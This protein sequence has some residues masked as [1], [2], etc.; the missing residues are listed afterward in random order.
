ML[1]F[2]DKA[3]RLRWK[4]TLI[5]AASVVLAIVVLGIGLGYGLKKHNNSSSSSSSGTGTGSTPINNSTDLCATINTTST[6]TNPVKLAST[7]VFLGNV[8]SNNTNDV[9][10]TGWQGNIGSDWIITFADTVPCKGAD[11]YKCAGLEASNSAALATSNP[12][13]Y[14][15]IK[16][17]TTDHAEQFIPRF[18]NESVSGI[19]LWPSAVLEIGTNMGIVY[20]TRLNRSDAS[21]LFVEGTGCA[22]VDTS[23]ARPIAT[24][25]TGN[26]PS[27]SPQQ[28]RKELNI[29]SNSSMVGHRRTIFW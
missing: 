7:P 26:I 22:T 11:H 20:Y 17:G 27:I 5:I 8:T 21:D 16:V 14:E 4:R 6:S 28:N 29:S 1:F 10:D 24:R 2:R 18:A 23:G 9:R 15:D 25:K 3:G 19:A 13:D 12:D